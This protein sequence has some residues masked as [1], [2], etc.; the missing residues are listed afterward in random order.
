MMLENFINRVNGVIIGIDNVPA[1]EGQAVQL[2]AEWCRSV[3]LPYQWS[4]PAYWWDDADST[5]LEHW[6]KVSAI[7]REEGIYPVPG[8]IV[9]FSS[10][11]PGSGGA[12]H[13]SIFLRLTGEYSWEGLD[14]N[15]GGKSTHKQSHTWAYVIGWFTPKNPSVL[16][17]PTPTA[18]AD[19]TSYAP[20]DVQ[21][22]GAKIVTALRQPTILYNLAD[23]SYESLVQ[24]PLNYVPQGTEITV[25][26]IAKHRLG[27]NYYMPDSQKAEGYLLEDC[28]SYGEED[29][30]EEVKE[31][32]V[33]DP[34][35]NKIFSPL[36]SPNMNDTV[37]VTR[38]IPRYTSMS[39]ALAQKNPSGDISP[40]RYFVY[41]RAPNGM[42]S[43]TSQ[44]G[45]SMR[46]WINPKDLED[47]PEPPAFNWA[48][49]YSAYKQPTF[50]E[51]TDD[52]KIIDL[53]GKRK[54]LPIKKK[55]LISLDGE[56]IYD[57]KPHGVPSVTNKVNQQYVVPMEILRRKPVTIYTQKVPTPPPIMPEILSTPLPEIPQYPSRPYNTLPN[58]PASAKLYTW[59][60]DR[61]K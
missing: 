2:I 13:A 39:D 52:A 8:D 18:I 54:T 38:R 9:I 5:F 28:E 45:Q 44:P 34:A 6:Q 3:G 11:L 41:K 33:K 20:Y 47:L 7:H 42:L 59:I 23:V 31:I 21:L 53:S 1:N 43:I 48:K 26:A 46:S 60:K 50:F 24:N 27:G 51:A 4:L 10:E 12:G 37:M 40:T 19:A 29:A 32:P 14:A 56:L 16:E 55:Q 61:F 30:A 57:N 35:S 17:S 22:I 58:L 49:S 25:T 36:S 15:W